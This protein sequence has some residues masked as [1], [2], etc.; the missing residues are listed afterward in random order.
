MKKKKRGKKRLGGGNVKTKR[1][2][3]Y[4]PSTTDRD[5]LRRVKK[6]F[7]GNVSAY[8]RQLVL[9]DLEAEVTAG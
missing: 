9:R 3:V 6:Y 5:M 1:R 7:N 8:F 4:L 2:M